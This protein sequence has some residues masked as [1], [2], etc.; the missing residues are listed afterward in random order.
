MKLLLRR[1]ANGIG[2]WLFMLA[3][4]KH[5][6]EAYPDVEVLVDFRSGEQA[7]VPLIREAYKASDVECSVWT[8]Q[9]TRFDREIEHVIYPTER[10]ANG[11]PYIAGMVAQISRVLGAKISY[12]R[13]LVPRFV[14]PIAPPDPEHPEGV[15]AIAP[16]FKLKVK[17][18]TF[19]RF[20]GL[21]GVLRQDLPDTEL[22]Q[23]GAKGERPIRCTRPCL[24]L[25]F[26][27]LASILGGSRCVVTHENGIAVLAGFL[28]VP[29][30]TIYMRGDMRRLGFDERARKLMHPTVDRI[31]YEV[32]E[33]IAA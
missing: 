9:H 1:Q 19:P 23:V 6:N 27:D 30:V 29:Q 2:D 12:D 26:P 5:V 18:W 32:L 11:Q 21:A 20:E 22:V 13:E 15:I 7:F 33:A 10:N 24:G 28:G 16:G 31:R 17:D 4:I 8:G 25:S 14:Y 3:A